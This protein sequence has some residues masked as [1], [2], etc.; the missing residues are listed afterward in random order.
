MTPN[1]PSHPFYTFAIA[2]RGFRVVETG[3]D[4]NSKFV[5]QVDHKSHRRADRIPTPGRSAHMTHFVRATLDL[6]NFATAGRP[7]LSAVDQS[8]PC[9]IVASTSSKSCVQRDDRLVMRQRRAV[10]RRQLIYL[11]YCSIWQRIASVRE[12]N[13]RRP[14]A[15]SISSTNMPTFELSCVFVRL[16]RCS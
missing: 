13:E 12:L 16:I 2:F 14:N 11:F 7:K 5:I 6:K 3:A 9:T 15:V 4:W 8:R 10:H 1:H